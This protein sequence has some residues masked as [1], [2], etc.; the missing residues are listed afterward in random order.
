MVVVLAGIVED[1]GIL[2]ER[3]LDDFLEGFAL[4][5]SPLDRVIAVG[6]VGLVMLVVV[7]FQ[8]FLRH[9]GRKGVM[10]VGQIRERKGH[11]AMSRMVGDE[12]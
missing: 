3:T 10:G 7:K 6:D 5:F 2:P 11:G 4:E 12:V 8:R 1:R 9:V